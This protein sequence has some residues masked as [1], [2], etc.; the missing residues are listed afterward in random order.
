MIYL[1]LRAN[2]AVHKAFE[3]RFDVSCA[4][5]FLGVKVFRS[6]YVRGVP[7]FAP[8]KILDGDLGAG[9]GFETFPLY[10]LGFMKDERKKNECR[11]N[12]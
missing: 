2:V 8:A 12:D 3:G 9:V 4:G 1:D 6:S 7:R 5:S 11:K 10:A